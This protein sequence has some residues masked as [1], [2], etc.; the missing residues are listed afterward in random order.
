M[1]QTNQSGFHWDKL[2]K[3]MHM[4]DSYFSVDFSK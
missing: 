4:R 2:I 1:R 3:T